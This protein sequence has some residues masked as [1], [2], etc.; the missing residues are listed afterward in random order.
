MLS[1]NSCAP[2]PPH[3]LLSLTCVLPSSWV[4][5]YF[6]ETIFYHIKLYFPQHF[7]IVL[8][9]YPGSC[10]PSPHPA[11]ALPASYPASALPAPTLLLLSQPPT[12][13]LLSQPP[14]LHLLPQ[15]LCP[16]VAVSELYA[17]LFIF[18]CKVRSLGK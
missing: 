7:S 14:T 2:E 18:S 3:L 8:E 17:S 1:Q 16:H 5:H 6:G 4:D 15:P 13:L 12:L 9:K 10:S 11:L